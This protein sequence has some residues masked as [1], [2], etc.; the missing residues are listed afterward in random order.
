M[1]T[2]GKVDYSGGFDF[3][4]LPQ[5]FTQSFVDRVA[6]PKTILQLHRRR[7]N[8]AASRSRA[9]TK[10]VCTEEDGEEGDDVNQVLDAVSIQNMVDDFLS[11]D[12]LR[13]LSTIELGDAVRVLVEKER[14]MAIEE[15]H[16]LSTT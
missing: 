4:F 1:G 7:A 3:S 16:F 8:A 9:S 6:N 11:H 10:H 2:A 14:P 12:A 5:R 15:Y 13:L